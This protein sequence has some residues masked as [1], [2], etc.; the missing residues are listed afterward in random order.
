[1]TITHG[2]LNATLGDARSRAKFHDETWYVI[3]IDNGYGN[4]CYRHCSEPY[5]N[6]AEFEALEGKIEW[7]VL[8]DGTCE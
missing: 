8:P 6:S 4:R 3:T 1:M 5:L 7:A 2:N